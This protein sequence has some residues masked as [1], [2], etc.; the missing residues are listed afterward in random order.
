[1][2]RLQVEKVSQQQR[3]A[4]E[5]LYCICRKPYNASLVYISCDIC[6]CWFHAKCV[7]LTSKQVDAV[8]EFVCPGCEASTGQKTSWKD[9]EARRAE[10]TA[11]KADREVRRCLER[12]LCKV[13]RRHARDRA[14]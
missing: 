5:D 9:A 13:E 1:M 8:D 11:V 10:R 3:T 2:L 7:G 6:E 14:N 12:L 4:E